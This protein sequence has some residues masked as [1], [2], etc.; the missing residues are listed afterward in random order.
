MRKTAYV[1]KILIVFCYRMLKYIAFRGKIWRL[2][3]V[4][5]LDDQLANSDYEFFF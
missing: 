3:Q 2:N 1:R 4:P 5:I